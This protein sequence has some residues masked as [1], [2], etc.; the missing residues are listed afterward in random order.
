MGIQIRGRRVWDR[1]TPGNDPEP[2]P[3]GWP[4]ETTTGP[5]AAGYN[6]TQVYNG[7]GTVS[8]NGTVLENLILPPGLEVTASDVR[9]QG[10]LVEGWTDDSVD[11][12]AIYV[13]PQAANV[14][15][16][17]C[18]IRGDGTLGGSPA[19]GI[20]LLGPNF[21]MSRCN[22]W[23]VAGDG[24]TID[25]TGTASDNFVH[26]FVDRAGVHYD[27]LHWPGTDLSGP[28]LVEHNRVEVWGVEGLTCCIGLPDVT[29][30]LVVCRGNLVAG[31]NFALIG[32]AAGTV[33]EDN[34]FSTVFSPD[35]GNYAPTAFLSPDSVFSGNVWHDGPNE[36]ELVPL[37]YG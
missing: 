2:P 28:A 13:R 21:T 14:Q 1:S 11:W 25:N 33:I 5:A 24:V 3:S 20:K 34:H 26:D 18:E 4:D 10:C 23:S 30:P 19:C 7:P 29:A 22:I 36:G 9:I 17:D 15:V 37:G 31:G 6:P 12:P 8:T 27:G 16:L 32:G 35:C